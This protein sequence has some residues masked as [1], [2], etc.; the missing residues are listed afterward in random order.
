MDL[1][2]EEYFRQKAE[3]LQ[4]LIVNCRTAATTTT[5]SYVWT[6][7]TTVCD[8]VSVVTTVIPFKNGAMKDVTLFSDET[9][10]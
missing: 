3:K 9:Q 6:H 5:T 1:E 4:N 2:K 7:R 10:R 8:V